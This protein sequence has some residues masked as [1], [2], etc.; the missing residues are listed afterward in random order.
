MNATEARAAVAAALS[1]LSDDRSVD[2][3][4]RETRGTAVDGCDEELESGLTAGGGEGV[5][6]SMGVTDGCGD[7]EREPD[8]NC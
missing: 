4:L 6:D 5:G 8:R 7:G 3:R 2:L 1:I